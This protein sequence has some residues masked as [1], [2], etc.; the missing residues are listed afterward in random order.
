[1]T[2]Q[3]KPYAS[4][5]SENAAHATLKAGPFADPDD[6]IVNSILTLSETTRKICA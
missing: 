6:G 5:T 1:M 4:L 3:T 2:H